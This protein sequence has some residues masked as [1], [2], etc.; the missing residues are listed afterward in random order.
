MGKACLS[1]LKEGLS[2]TGVQ[3]SP[4]VKVMLKQ[5]PGRSQ[6]PLIIPANVCLSF[7]DPYKVKISSV[8][9][10]TVDF[11]VCE[12]SACWGVRP[13]P[14]PLHLPFLK[15]SYMVFVTHEF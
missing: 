2:P 15:I 1:L 14:P 3:S 8:G 6:R 5:H 11:L 4:G 12:S 13:P 9:A 10:L 7:A